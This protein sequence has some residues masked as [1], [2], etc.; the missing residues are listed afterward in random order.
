MQLLNDVEAT[1]ALLSIARTSLYAEVRA[2]R[3]ATV[4]R[5]KRTFFHRDE[6]ERYV[7]S[8]ARPRPTIE[9]R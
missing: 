8:L 3:I 6:I 9:G 4:K 1:C 5:G 2:G 7:A